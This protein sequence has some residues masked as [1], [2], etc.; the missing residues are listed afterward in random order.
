MENMKY[1]LTAHI[2]SAESNY[3]NEEP[4]L[5]KFRAVSVASNQIPAPTEIMM[6]MPPSLVLQI[7][8]L[9]KVKITV[10]FI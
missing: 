8:D 1:E 4:S 10:E 2:V 6:P 9:R 7:G 3:S 5:L